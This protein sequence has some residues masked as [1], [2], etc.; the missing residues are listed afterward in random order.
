MTDSIIIVLGFGF[1]VGW[2]LNSMYRQYRDDKMFR[3]IIEKIDAEEEAITKKIVEEVYNHLPICYVEKHGNKDYLLYNR[4][5]D[6]FMYQGK[7]YE[8]ICSQWDDDDYW[9][10]IPK[11]TE[12]LDVLI[13][14]FNEKVRNS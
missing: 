11:H 5:T 4:D 6:A 8:E 12:K 13:D 14:V 2:A 10:D 3:V 1:I 7:S 9:T